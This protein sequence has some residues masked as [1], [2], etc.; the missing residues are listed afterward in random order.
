M[1]S[2][3]DEV[4]DHHWGSLVASSPIL[5]T[6]LGLD[7]NQD[8]YDDLTPAG[9][10]TRYQL[11]MDTLDRLDQAMP[12]DDTDRV[13]VSAMR[14]SLG[15]EA[16]SHD[17]GYDLLTLNGIASGVH[18]IREVYDAMPT[19]TPD[20]VS[21]VA[22]RLQA[23][24]AALD[25]WLQTQRA[26]IDAGIAPA[27]RQVNL[28]VEQITSWTGDGGFFD[29]YL[30]RTASDDL[31]DSVRSELAEGIDAAKANFRRTAE[32]LATEIAP[33][34]TETDAVGID[35]YRLASRQFV[36]TTVDLAETYEWG[37]QELARIEQLQRETAERIRPGASVKEAMAVLDADPAY[38]ISGTEALRAWMQE[39]A[40]E[41]ISTLDGTHF[42]VPEQARHIE[43]MIAPTHD[44]GVYYTPPSEDF[45][46]PGRMWWSVPEGVDTFTTW[47]ELT[48]VYHEG[49][50]GHH[51]Q[52]SS[53][54]AARDELNSW[55]RNY[56]SSGYGEGWALYAEWLMADLG[57]MD[58]PGHFM[59][60]LDGQSMRAARVVLDIGLHCQ[61]EAP[62]E[63]GGEWNWDKAWTF[64]NN[65]VS[66]DEGSARYEVNRYFGWPGQAPSYKLGERTWLELRE[67]AK[68]K[69]PNFDL[70]EYHTKV[71]RMGALPL[72]V[73]R[74]AV[75]S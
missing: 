44:G 57:Y 60:L 49:A 68:A 7:L 24:G 16:E 61:F 52:T 64:F 27:I 18:E 5:A 48:T 46:R 37:K 14:S 63:V 6:A 56:W 69:D 26:S 50:P 15:L 33:L 35:R 3:V 22:R 70:K 47:R 59:G 21:T 43:G 12:A 10:E 36:G 45:S 13:T 51:L 75:L 40:D 54:I 67:A 20:Q 38:Q 30:K 65:H 2:E 73:L 62:E 23:T 1:G 4:A 66:M 9:M 41:A 31:P 28:L 29:D 53:A 17:K 42:E 34:A 11:V 55:R 8:E 25:G 19:E 32:T 71:L 74:R 39:R 58:D 72:D